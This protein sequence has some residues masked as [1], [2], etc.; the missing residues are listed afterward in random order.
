M[1][2]Y[3]ERQEEARQEAI[4]WQMKASEENYSM[5]E[6]AEWGD[7]FRKLGKRFGLIREFEEN[8]IPC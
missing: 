1:K 5:E 4:D 7:Y 3:R 8:C 6:L 2:T